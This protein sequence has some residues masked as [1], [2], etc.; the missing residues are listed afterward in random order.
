MVLGFVFIRR[1][2]LEEHGWLG[3]NDENVPRPK[4]AYA[5]V[6]FC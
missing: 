6:N 5:N 4:L 3:R 1:N 2:N